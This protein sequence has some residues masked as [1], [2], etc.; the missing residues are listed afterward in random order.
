MTKNAALITIGD[1]LMIGQVVDTNSSFIS[2]QL[3]LAG[4]W[5]SLRV[6]VGDEAQSIL[7]ALDTA[8][9][10]ADVVIITGGL[11]PTKD[12]ITKEV[13]CRYFGGK[14]VINNEALENVKSI[15]S[16][17]NK[18]LIESNYKQAEV[19]ETCTVL[20][21]KN[22][23]AP[24]MFFSKNDKL[25]FSLP[26]VPFEM[27][28]LVNEYVIPIIQQRFQ[29]PKIVHRHILTIGL[30]ESFLAEKI[31]SIEDSLPPSI[32]LAYLPDSGL[33]KL[34]LTATDGSDEATLAQLDSA[35][36]QIRKITAEYFVCDEDIKIETVIGRLLSEKK[37]TLATAESCTGGYIAHLLTA[38]PKSSNYFTGSVVCYDKRIKSEV[39]GVDKQLID[40]EGTVNE[41]V[42]VQLARGVLTALGS[43]YAIGITGLMG[44]DAGDED[45]P[46]GTTWIAVGN[47]NTI[48]AKEFLFRFSRRKNIQNAATQALNMLR[49]FIKNQEK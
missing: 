35:A 16:R 32:K 40:A 44:P 48:V 19:P 34:R 6:S 7:Q 4:L 17:L 49:L 24:A 37:K 13:L 18:P 33:V 47:K 15:F 3:I 41:A 38:N 36:S 28:A 23:T 31:K 30:G 45:K 1:E 11:G 20:L 21:N 5:V 27:E 43:D 10:K 12:D 46:V 9:A 25:F 2:Q 14:M 26:G 22:G 29:L 8:A 42:A 39:L